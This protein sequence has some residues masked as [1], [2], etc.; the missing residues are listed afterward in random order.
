MLTRTELGALSLGPQNNGLFA[1]TEER[2]D[3]DPGSR[4][5]FGALES[6]AGLIASRFPPLQLGSCRLRR[7]PNSGEVRNPSPCG[8]GS[9]WG[10]GLEAAER[11]QPGPTSSPSWSPGVRGPAQGRGCPEGA[12]RTVLCVKHV[13]SGALGEGIQY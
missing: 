3:L 1:L 12:A 10:A 8:A 5:G 6:A 11:K 9:I 2:D 7:M 13:R 4:I